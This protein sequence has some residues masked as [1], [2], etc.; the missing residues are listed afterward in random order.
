MSA[1]QQ[2]F[3]LDSSY[4]AWFLDHLQQAGF[5]PE[6]IQIT[7]NALAIAKRSTKA[8]ADLRDATQ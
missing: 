2:A 1:A 3:S 6:Q 7:D 4:H 8:V 5:S